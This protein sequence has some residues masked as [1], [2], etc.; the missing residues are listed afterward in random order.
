MVGVA[1][2]GFEELEVGEVGGDAGDGLDAGGEGREEGVVGAASHF[3]EDFADDAD[4]GVR[5]ECGLGEDD[6]VVGGGVVGV[7]ERGCGGCGAF[8]DG[9]AGGHV[10]EALGAAGADD[11]N[12]GH[13][14]ADEGDV[15]EA[16]HPA[17]EAVPKGELSAVEP[18]HLQAERPF[19][20]ALTVEGG[21]ADEVV[22]E[23]GDVDEVEA[24]TGTH[25][26]VEREGE[27]GEGDGHGH[28]DA[29]VYDGGEY[30]VEQSG[31][32]VFDVDVLDGADGNVHRGEK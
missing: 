19:A 23:E 20:E 13:G 22:G 16:E 27:P 4:V 10:A 18:H 15:H 14:A 6:G 3:G 9:G 21:L 17:Q 1:E 28:E 2:E 5:E 25:G 7:G 31:W 11:G 8:D 32:D 26:L 12:D 30:A 24:P 29:I